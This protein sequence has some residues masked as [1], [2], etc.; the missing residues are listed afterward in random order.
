MGVLPPILE[1]SE[2]YLRKS[3]ED[4]VSRMYD[5]EYQNRRLCLR[6][7][8][9]AATIRAYVDNLQDSSLPVRLS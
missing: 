5:F 1:H 7:E 2:L 8:L 3:G 9:T 4:I 6:P